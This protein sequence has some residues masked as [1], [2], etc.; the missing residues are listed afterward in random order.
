M[1]NVVHLGSP[2]LA[3]IPG[4][5]ASGVA[6]GI[7]PDGALDL[8]LVAADVPC[9]SAAVFTKNCV[10]AAPVLYDRELLQSG[11]PIQA[12]VINSGCDNACTG[13]RGLE[14][15]R[16]MAAMVGD[17]LDMPADSTFVMSTGVIGQHLPMEK[18]AFG[19]TPDGTP[20]D[21]YVLKNPSGMQ[22]RITNYGGI[23]VAL[24]APDRHGDL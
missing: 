11:K 21:L 10:Q 2:N 16:R 15:T 9:V 3:A 6:C 14:D 23:V 1:T 22:A 20:V 18:I 7:K 17:A 8:A 5:R 13:E 4:F 19:K 24:L 12:V